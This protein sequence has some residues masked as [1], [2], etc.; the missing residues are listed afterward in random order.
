MRTRA[1]AAL[2]GLAAGCSPDLASPRPSPVAPPVTSPAPAAGGEARAGFIGV[3]MASATVALTSQLEAR[4]ERL[5]VRP[6]DAVHAGDVL[7]ELDTTAAR[8]ELAIANAEL[9]SANAGLRRAELEGREARERLDRRSLTIALPGGGTVGT[10]S[11]EELSGARYQEQLATVKIEAARAAVLEKRAHCDELR[12][13]AAEGTVRAPFDG[14]ISER[15]VDEGAI[16]RKGDSIVRLI[17]ASALKVRFAIPEAAASRV[18]VGTAI[19][20]ATDGLELAGHVEK[21]APEVD[22]AARM[23]F[24]EAALTVPEPARGRLRSGAIARVALD[25]PASQ[26]A[27]R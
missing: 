1:L 19:R 16:L 22:A 15:F 14:V 7:A 4:V 27:N 23:V 8:K 5:R 24:A 11:K 6:G 13:M 21:V 12:A 9:L 17:E 2:L 10:V 3:V 20:V 18:Q 25:T 26:Q